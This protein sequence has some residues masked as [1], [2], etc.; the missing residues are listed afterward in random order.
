M[1]RDDS[2]YIYG[3]FW[4]DKRR[5]GKAA[6]LWQIA[7]YEAGTRQ[8]RYRS[9]RCKGLDDAKGAIHGY[10]ESLRAK[11]PQKPEDATLL[12]LLFNYWEEHGR[13]ADSAA[14]I[15]SSIRQ[16]IG[17]LMQDEATADVT[18]AQ[19]N[20]L[21]F[22]RFRVWR[23]APHS[24]DVPWGG[25][26]YRHSSPGVS[27]E[28]VQRNLDDIRAALNHNTKGRLP[29]VPKVA[30]VAEKYR[31]QPRDLLLSREQ[32]GAII[33]YAAYDIATLRWILV[34]LGTMMRPDA[35]LAMHPRRQYREGLLDLHPPEWDRTKKHNPVVPAIPELRPWLV[36]WAANPHSPVLS[37]KRWWRTMRANLG[38]PT[39]TVPKTIRHTIASRLRNIRVPNEE[40]ETALGH[41][42]LKRTSRVYAKYDPDYLANVSKA[43]SIVWADY[44][45]AAQEWLAVH[46]LSIPKRG[47]N[48]TVVRNGGNLR[49]MVVRGDGLEPPTLS[50]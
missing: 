20:P 24:Y 28:A 36:A 44:C 42:V 38:L 31:S 19:L 49:N 17:F 6:G 18:V 48:L 7:W 25:K 30:S 8:V 23:M 5:D 41:L 37:R 34:M 2:P 3:D 11:G 27:G 46:S 16:F 10:V 4:L 40:L 43:L 45:A 33:G 15:A 13:N 21:L 9:T 47:Q 22:E 50:V 12:P 29:W 14:Q 1:A 35:A 32:M 26:D 39:M